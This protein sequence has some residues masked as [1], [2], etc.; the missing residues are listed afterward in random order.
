MASSRPVVGQGPMEQPGRDQSV[1]DPYPDSRRSLERRQPS[2]G[3]CCGRDRHLGE[4]CVRPSPGVSGVGR[5]TA[6]PEHP[7]LE[8]EYHYWRC[9]GASFGFRSRTPTP[10]T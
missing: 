7:D 5:P 2:S 6:H 10:W 3:L 1:S 8:A 9:R 4:S